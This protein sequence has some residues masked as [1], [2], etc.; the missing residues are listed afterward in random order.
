MKYTCWNKSCECNRTH[1][2]ATSLLVC[3][4]YFGWPPEPSLGE[5]KGL[6]GKGVSVLHVERSSVTMNTETVVEDIARLS[7]ILYL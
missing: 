2:T 6:T 4:K 7:S 5:V 3:Y 1:G